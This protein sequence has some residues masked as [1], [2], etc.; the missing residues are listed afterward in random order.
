MS[1]SDKVIVLNRGRLEQVGGPEDIYRDPRSAFVGDF[2]GESNLISATVTDVGPEGFLRV[3]FPG[4]A[5]AGARSV[6][7]GTQSRP[8]DAV[9]LLVRAESVQLSSGRRSDGD[10]F[11]GVVSERSFLGAT[12][13][14]YIR[15]EEGG[16]VVIADL[17]GAPPAWAASGARVYVGWASDAALAYPSASMPPAGSPT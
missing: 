5:T 17:A 7:A 11:P 4:G 14:L 16:Q 15:A 8:G 3:E 2:I 6:R 9:T 13:R 12:T 10:C 1:M